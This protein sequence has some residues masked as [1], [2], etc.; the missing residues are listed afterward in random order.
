MIIVNFITA[1]RLIGALLL[2][3]IYY[4]YG[5]NITS[6]IIIGL[7][8][9]DTIDG[10][11]ARKLKVSTFFGSIMDALSDKILNVMAFIILGFEYNLMLAP[12]IVEIA[13]LYTMYS[14]YRYGGN[15]QSSRTGKNKTIIVDIFV[16]ISFVL[17]SLPTLNNNIKFINILIDYTEILI[18]VFS[19]VILTACLF[20][21]LDYLK[22]NHESRMNPKCKEIKNEKKEKKPKELVFKQL[23][24]TEYYS[25]HKNESIMKQFYV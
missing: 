5:V 9:S 13:I 16:A 22:K 7:F 17:L 18:N 19:V 14:T 8:L 21:L 3:I 25:I 12:L 1:I 10:Y 23:F 15:I 2:P 20:A 6:V 24:D 11:L 4:K